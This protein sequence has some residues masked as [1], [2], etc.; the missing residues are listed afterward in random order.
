MD[1]SSLSNNKLKDKKM[2]N[3][4]KPTVSA[5]FYMCVKTDET[6]NICDTIFK[7]MPGTTLGDNSVELANRSGY[8]LGNQVAMLNSIINNS[9][10]VNGN[11]LPDFVPPQVARGGINTISKMNAYLEVVYTYF[12][13]Y[14]PTEDFI[15]DL[16]AAGNVTPENGI[17]NTWIVQLQTIFYNYSK[18]LTVL[19][20]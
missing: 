15:I 11:V 19:M 8:T 3:I 18:N 17:D 14:Y 12:F 20:N 4:V 6:P 2:P 7:V 16:T 9:I 1:T 10:S 13:N 5:L